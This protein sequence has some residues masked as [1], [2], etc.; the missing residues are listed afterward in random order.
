MITL[1]KQPDHPLMLN[2]NIKG[3]R[4]V[5]SS[6]ADEKRKRGTSVQKVLDGR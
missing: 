6:F 4:N 1:L 5:E 3:R 2:R